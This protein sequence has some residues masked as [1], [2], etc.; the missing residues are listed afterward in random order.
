MTILK[1]Y[2]ETLNELHDAYVKSQNCN[3]DEKSYYAAKIH[4][5]EEYLE[6][7]IT[8]IDSN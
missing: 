1:V 4:E 2:E 3:Y 6:S 5:L 7:L 8:L